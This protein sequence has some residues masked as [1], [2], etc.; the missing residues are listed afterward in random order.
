MAQTA[1]SARRRPAPR[2]T[3]ATTR[4]RTTLRRRQPQPSNAQ[5]LL[6]ALG[7]A[8]PA[9]ARKAG[10]APGGGKGRAGLALLGAGAGL[11][12]LKGRS[13]RR[14]RAAEVE[15]EPVVVAPMPDPLGAPTQPISPAV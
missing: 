10:S 3:I 2:R 5:R 9:A 4:P 11:A 1:K 14:N 15:P 8:L 7:G 12:A 13:K 6:G